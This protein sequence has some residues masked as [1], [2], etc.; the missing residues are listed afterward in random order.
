MGADSARVKVGF[1]DITALA[2]CVVLD[3]SR[4]TAGTFQYAPQYGV[5][6]G[7]WSCSI[8]RAVGTGA[9]QAFPTALAFTSSAIAQPATDA[10][11]LSGTDTVVFTTD[12]VGSAGVVDIWAMLK[13]DR[14][15]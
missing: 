11:D 15:G 10:Q 14:G 7:S 1:L 2:R 3:V 8:K 9:P 4:Y 12:T 13:A 6:V 5:N